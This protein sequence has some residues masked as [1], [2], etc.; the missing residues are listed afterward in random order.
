MNFVYRNH[1]S[2]HLHF[3][4]DFEPHEQ[5]EQILS[6]ILETEK[7]KSTGTNGIADVFES[8][9]AIRDQIDH[10]KATYRKCAETRKRKNLC[11]NQ[12]DIQSLQQFISSHLKA[13]WPSKCEILKFGEV[14][15]KKQMRFQHRTGT[16]PGCTSF[17]IEIHT[18]DTKETF[19]ITSYKTQIHDAIGL[20]IDF[21]KHSL[22]TV[23]GYIRSI[24][25]D[26]Q[27]PVS[28]KW[29]ELKLCSKQ[30]DTPN[31]NMVIEVICTVSAR[32]YFFLML[33]RFKTEEVR[34]WIKE[35]ADLINDQLRDNHAVKFQCPGLHHYILQLGMREK[36]L[37]KHRFIGKGAKNHVFTSDESSLPNEMKSET[38]ERRRDYR[39]W[40]R[41]SVGDD[42]KVNVED[43]LQQLIGEMSSI[44]L[45]NHN[46]LQC[47][48]NSKYRQTKQYD[49][50]DH[51]HRYSGWCT[52]WNVKRGFGFIQID[53]HSESYFVHQS[54]VYGNGGQPLPEGIKVELDI[55]DDG[56]G[57][58]KAV[59]VSVFQT[60]R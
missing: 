38:V 57:R 51:I 56:N 36:T 1:S 18:D 50:I 46:T 14:P 48:W 39:R 15:F 32:H 54:E 9:M 11:Q 3:K 7:A 30:S 2:K 31:G 25:A 43:D 47:S 20:Y 19:N 40:S 8:V 41:S 49:G 60:V 17:K 29:F 27:H 6:S 42:K 33:Y 24:V 45:T 21:M 26:Y 4:F 5:F 10:Y 53:N 59:N 34:K 44:S 35:Y 16:L 13:P 12:K 28:E 58:K 37:L 22:A 52:H 23:E 55:E